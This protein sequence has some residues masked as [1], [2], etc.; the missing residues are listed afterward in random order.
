MKQNNMF[1]RSLLKVASWTLAHASWMT[2]TL[3]PVAMGKAAEKNSVDYYKQQVREIGLDKKITA[4]E[5]WEKVKNDLPGYAY[6]EIEQ[7]VKQNPNALMPK[8]EV[9]SSKTSDGQVIPVITFTENG[10]T[11]TIQMYG[12]KDKFMKYNNTVVSENDSKTPSTLFQ[13]LIDGDSKLNKQYQ[14]GLKKQRQVSGTSAKNTT[15]KSNGLFSQMNKNMWKKMTMEQRVSYFIQMRMMYLDAKKVTELNSKNGKKTSSFNQLEMIYKAIFQDAEAQVPSD[16]A[17]LG[18]S[19][20]KHVVTSLDGKKKIS[21]PYDAQSCIV[22][23]YVGKYV[24]MVNNV[25]GQKRPGCSVDVATANYANK[26]GLEYVVDANKQCMND[27][28]VSGIACNPIIYGYPNGSP[29]CVSKNSQEF[30]IATHWEGPCDTASRLSYTKDVVDTQG[31]DYSK[32]VPRSAQEEAIR[33]DQETQNLAL[34]KSFIEGVLTKKDANLLALFKDGKWSQALEDEINR[35]GSQFDK[36][37]EEAIAICEKDI[38]AKHEKNQKGACDQLHRRKLFYKEFIKT[39]KKDEPTV[40]TSGDVTTPTVCPADPDPTNPCI[41]PEPVAQCDQYPPLKVGAELNTDCTCTNKEGANGNIPKED[42]PGFFQKLFNTKANKQF[43]KPS[44]EDGT[45]KSKKSTNNDQQRE[46]SCKFGPN[47]WLIGGGALAIGGI[48]ALLLVKKKTKTVTNTVTNTVTETVTNTVDN[49]VTCK[50][51]KYPVIIAMTSDTPSKPVY[52]CVCPP[53]GK[54]YLQN[55]T[56]VDITPNPLTCACEPP[57]T[58]GG[59]GNNPNDDNGSGGV[60]G[61]N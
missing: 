18:T 51:P 10:K 53:C 12:E 37:I 27:K 1:T 28:G 46:Y 22:A 13:K 52:N 50:A 30:Q 29:I 26:S 40:V 24:P 15:T 19:D 55:G 34:T 36:E 58:E 20:K 31:K 17:K 23:G 42:Q 2:M 39:L 61:Q 44:T 7:A 57:P 4:K 45:R 14:D 48:V 3:S 47:W 60:P 33:K 6:F 41:E 21:I 5:F 43:K 49:T 38:T 8:F 56:A 54:Y 16:A 25:N 9:S 35:M 59:S 32:I 11:S